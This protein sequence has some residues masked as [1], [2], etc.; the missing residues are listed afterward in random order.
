M[1]AAFGDAA[2]GGMARGGMARA[3]Q[4]EFPG[5]SPDPRY[6]CVHTKKVVMQLTARSFSHRTKTIALRELGRWAF[7]FVLMS[8]PTFAQAPVSFPGG[9][10]T[11]SEDFQDW[12]L[13]CTIQQGVKRCGIS[14]QQMES[15]GQQRLLAVELQPKGDRLEGVLFLPFGLA[16]DKGVAL[17]VGDAAIGTLRF[18][19]CLP[20]GCVVPLSL[21][22]KALAAL[23]KGTDLRIE[24]TADGGPAQGFTISLKGF[25]PALDRVAV[26]MK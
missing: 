25:G 10:Q 5:F 24:A 6:S 12:R 15:K 19:T 4:A 7:A 9:A 8:G 1:S 14:Q 20:Q 23:R 11:V 26:L 3:S 21:D 22:A 18:S 16:V 2:C 17:K 13:R